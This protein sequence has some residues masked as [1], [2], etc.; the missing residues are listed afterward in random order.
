MVDAQVMRSVVVLTQTLA[1]VT[2]CAT[3]HSPSP[4]TFALFDRLILL[5]RGRVA[6]FGDSGARTRAPYPAA[7]CSPPHARRCATAPLLA[8]WLTA[9][10]RS[11]T[12]CATLCLS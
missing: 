12:L 8:R 5:L 7:P 2:V 6:Y 3:I 1:S 4:Q 9:L 10:K 11:W